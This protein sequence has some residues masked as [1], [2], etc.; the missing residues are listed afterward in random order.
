MMKPTPFNWILS[1]CNIYSI[2]VI[3]SKQYLISEFWNYTESGFEISFIITLL[4]SEFFCFHYY[5]FLSGPDCWWKES[6]FSY[7]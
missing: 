3:S 6:P 1:T 2:F 5:S 4:F 7:L